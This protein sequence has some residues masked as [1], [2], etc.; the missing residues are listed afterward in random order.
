[1]RPYGAFFLMCIFLGGLQYPAYSCTSLLVT[2]GASADGSVMITY[3]CDGE[4][5][6]HLE[7][8]PAADNSEDLVEIT[9]WYGNVL[10]RIHQ[11][12]HTYAVVHLINEY[13]VAIGETTFGGRPELEDTLGLLGYWDLMTL[14]LQRAKTAREAIKVMVD[15]VNQYGYRSTGESLSIADPKEAW[16]MEI[17]GMGPVGKGAVWAALRVPDG[18]I[19]A[20]AN[21]ARIGEILWDDPQNCMY[22]A[23]VISFAIERNYYDPQSGRPFRFCDAYCPPTPQS[24]RPTE[25]RVWSI[26]RRAAPSLGL[27]PDYHRGLTG[28]QPYPLWIKPDK[29]LTLS[30]VFR[31]MR[32][33]FEGTDYD[34]TKGV[35]AGPYGSPYRW[36]PLKWAADS[37]E[38]IWERP[39]STQ[40]TAF[41]FVSQSRA[42]LPNPIGGVMWY[43]VDDTWFTCYTP[44]YCGIDSLPPSF[45]TGNLQEFSWESA[46]WVYNFVS[47]LCQ[48]KYLYMNEDVRKV[49]AEIEGNYLALQPL[50]EE[51]ALEIYGQNPQ[52]ALD[53]LTAYSV[54]GA[55]NMVARW[56]HLGEFLIMKY[57]DGYI[58]NAEGRPEEKGY[59]EDWLRRVV[60][61]RPEQYRLPK[62]DSVGASFR[63]TD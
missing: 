56:R 35:D 44:L 20:H 24:L 62:N 10:G 3:T 53:Y 41:S 19:C 1:M 39:I 23:N 16:I 25:T 34:L 28:A 17:I 2:S 55:E 33:H 61:E 48:L 51:A 30:D 31:L 12:P 11:V 6:P 40:Q 9:D 43:G 60:K 49:Q 59:P 15:L 36:R 37:S 52:L 38:Y 54:S 22:S 27:A 4:F 26:F 57:N 47:N 58:K 14:A 32:D 50:I 18:Y 13:Q 29:K 45:T 5:H 46:F 7:Y 42:W 63:L 21:Q 8:L